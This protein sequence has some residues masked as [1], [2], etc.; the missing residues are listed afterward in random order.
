MFLQTRRKA[1]RCNAMQ[2]MR[3][4]LGTRKLRTVKEGP[5]GCTMSSG[6]MSVRIGISTSLWW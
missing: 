5:S 1:L 2:C 6:L 3:L 4:S